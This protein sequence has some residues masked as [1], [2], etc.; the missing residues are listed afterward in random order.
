MVRLYNL[1]ITYTQEEIVMAAPDIKACFRFLRMHPYFS[2]SL[3]FVI[4][5]LFFLVTAKVFGSVVSASSWGPFRRAIMAM[6]QGNFG[7]KGLEVTHKN[8]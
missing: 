2:G 7:K 5:S 6:T 4:G 8:L 3:S 1:H